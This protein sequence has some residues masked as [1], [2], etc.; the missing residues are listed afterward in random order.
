MAT[1]SGS[2]KRSGSGGSRLR[3]RF[4]VMIKEI[5]ENRLLSDVLSSHNKLCHVD[6]LEF[7]KFPTSFINGFLGENCLQ[8]V[9]AM[10]V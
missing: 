7:S 9:E 3:Q 2:L 5:V 1:D 8:G 6:E 10:Q 4:L